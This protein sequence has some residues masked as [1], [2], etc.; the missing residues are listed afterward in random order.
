MTHPRTFASDNNS[1]AHPAMLVA[2]A[3]ANEGHLHAYGEDPWTARGVRALRGHLGEDA[4]VFFTFN[5]TGANVTALAALLRPGDAVLCPVSAHINT[6][7]CGAPERLTSAKLVGL[8]APDGKLTVGVV[9]PVVRASAGVE[10]IVQPRVASI[11]QVA[12]TG[13]VYTSDEVKALA[14]FCHDNGMYLH[15]DG[16][17]ISNA[18][19]SLGLPIAAFTRDAG[20]DVLSFGGTKNGMMMGE[21]VVFLRPE[22]AEGFRYV[23]KSSAQVASKMRYVGAQFAAMYGSSLWLEL[24]THANAMAKRLE[25]GARAAGVTFAYPVDANELFPVLAPADVPALRAV[26]DFYEWDA[27][28]DGTMVARWVTSWDTTEDDV[29]RFCEALSARREGI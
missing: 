12:E 9:E 7:E 19:A 5:G 27:R 16:A 23:R 6:D 3:E 15:M 14:V 26:A 28:D 20:V 2:I 8:P 13:A 21:A 17:R 1:G 11:S 22:L 4:E 10:H 24:A 18:A 25:A 29:D